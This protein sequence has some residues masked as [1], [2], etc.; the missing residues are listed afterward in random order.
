MKITV[1]EQTKTNLKFI[2]HSNIS[3]A[4]S[5][6]RILL[7]EVP[8]V[9]IDIVEIKENGT[10]LADEMLAH[11]IG[12]IPIRYTGNIISKE[13]CDCDGFCQKCSIRFTLKKSNNMDNPNSI[14]S[15]TGLDLQTSN[16]DVHCHNSLIVKLSPGQ[17]ID[18]TCIATLGNGKVHAKFCPITTVGFTYDKNNKTRATKLWVEEDVSK[19]WSTIDQPEEVDWNEIQEIEMNMEIVEG[20]GN[21][22]DFLIAA[23]E[24]FKKKMYEVLQDVK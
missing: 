13:D 5:L 19:E 1:I 10:V 23:I 6:R 4:N 2:L 21:P 24:I 16:P 9:A 7:S 11:R 8:M 22:K 3:F 20:L 15:V 18:M 14:I 17:K 12:L